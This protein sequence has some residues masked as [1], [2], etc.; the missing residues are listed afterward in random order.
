MKFGR[1]VF[2]PG[3]YH[4]FLYVKVSQAKCQTVDWKHPCVIGIG[5][6]AIVK[7]LTGYIIDFC[8]FNQNKAKIEIYKQWF[9]PPLIPIVNIRIK[10]V[11]GEI[12]CQNRLIDGILQRSRNIAELKAVC[13][14][15]INKMNESC[16]VLCK[17]MIWFKTVLVEKS[18]WPI[19]MITRWI[20][21]I[22]QG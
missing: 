20:M 5:N 12:R 3:R 21:A 4:L 18:T 13:D 19:R 1:I 16:F 7:N 9:D 11:W 10:C 2:F 8:L 22:T 14:L 17:Y 6:V 15:S